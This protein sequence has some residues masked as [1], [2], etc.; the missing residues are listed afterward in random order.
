MIVKDLI[1]LLKDCGIQISDVRVEGK[2]ILGFKTEIEKD[3]SPYTNILIAE[4]INE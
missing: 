4:E 3:G 2:E 1:K